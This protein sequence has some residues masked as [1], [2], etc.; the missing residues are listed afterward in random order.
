[1][2]QYAEGI[3]A[4]EDKESQKGLDTEGGGQ[5]G[6]GYSLKKNHSLKG[7]QPKLQVGSTL[8]ICHVQLKNFGHFSRSNGV[9]L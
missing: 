9:W 4:M 3:E 7:K 8:C 5:K 1:M 6:E 2:Q